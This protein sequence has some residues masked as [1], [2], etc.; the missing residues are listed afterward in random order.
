MAVTTDVGNP[1]DIH[2]TNKQDVAKRLAAT[3]LKNDYG[4]DIQAAGPM[5]ESVTFKK[6]KAV[7][8]FKNVG[9]GLMTK[10]KFGYLMGFEIAGDDKVFGYAKAYIENNKVIVEFPKKKKPAAVRYAW[11]D[12][13]IDANLFNADGFPANGFRTDDW[14]TITKGKKFE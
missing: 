10:D 3:A 12:S 7:I 13:P 2:P 5:Y 4:Y 9:K 6:G 14:N 8:T 1:A 11:A